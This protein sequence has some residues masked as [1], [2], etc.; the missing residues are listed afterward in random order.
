MAI[1]ASYIP[2]IG[3]NSRRAKKTRG[4]KVEV[5]VLAF[6]FKRKAPIVIYVLLRYF[7]Y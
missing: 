5:I 3:G 4:P 1:D 6:S 2:G 7:T